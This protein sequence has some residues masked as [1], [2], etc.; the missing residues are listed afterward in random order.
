VFSSG[1]HRYRKSL[2]PWRET[3]P[4]GVSYETLDLLDN[5]FLDNTQE[6][7]VPAGHYFMMGDNRDNATDSR[8]LSQVGYIPFTNLIGRAARIYYSVDRTSPT[9]ETTLRLGRIGA[10]VQ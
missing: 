8:V 4:N 1:G 6:Y 5:G 10:A 7:S 2:C 3:L 9:G